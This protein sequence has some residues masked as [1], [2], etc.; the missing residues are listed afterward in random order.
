M[1]LDEPAGHRAEVAYELMST[2]KFINFRGLGLQIQASGVLECRVFSQWAPENLNA[3]I[4]EE[5]FA[6][7]KDR[8]AALLA[9]SET[10]TS[11][12]ESRRQA[13]ELRYDYGQGAIRLCRLDG[14]KLIWDAGWPKRGPAV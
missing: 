14:S 6:V 1:R 8:L 13:W 11:L 4:A 9:G 3:E 7:G 12:L 10:F 5:E 2:G